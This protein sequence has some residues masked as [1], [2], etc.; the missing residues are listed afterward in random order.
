MLVWFGVLGAIGLA[1]IVQMPTI[2][3]AIDPRYGIVFLLDNQAIQ[4]KFAE[5]KTEIEALRGPAN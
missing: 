1:N 2:L 4:F 5:L 3:K